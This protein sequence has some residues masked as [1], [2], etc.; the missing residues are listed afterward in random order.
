VL[1]ELGCSTKTLGFDITAACS[2]FIVGL[3]TATQFIK[4]N[5]IVKY[6]QELGIQCLAGLM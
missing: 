2:G 1:A 3:I 5:S 6:R 4:G